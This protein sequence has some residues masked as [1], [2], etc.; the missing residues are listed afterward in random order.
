[1]ASVY[2]KVFTLYIS[3]KDLNDNFLC[4]HQRTSWKLHSRFYHTSQKSFRT[5]PS[6]F[7]DSS[8]NWGTDFFV[9]QMAKKKTD[10]A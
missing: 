4:S 3:F 10:I 7:V 1:M 2:P 8:E 6:D 5:W 9:T